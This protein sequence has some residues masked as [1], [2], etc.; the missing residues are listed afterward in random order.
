MTKR[1]GHLLCFVAFVATLGP[2]SGSAV[3]ARGGA[4]PFLGA[5]SGDAAFTSPQTVEFH[6]QGRAS[7]LGPSTNDGMSVLG[8]P[9]ETSEC[10]AGWGIPDVRTETLTAANG[11][12]LV[13]E[14]TGIA[15][16]A[17]ENVFQG[18]GVWEV[19]VGTGRF[20][21]ANGSGRVFARAD[22][23]DGTFECLLA[24]RISF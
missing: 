8:V 12:T 21:N 16:P 6:G 15:C 3:S 19:I 11:D 20:A 18:A 24:G 22:F 17:G 5:Y 2:V 10:R 1:I 9:I 7:L 4:V 13:I 14:M 23:T